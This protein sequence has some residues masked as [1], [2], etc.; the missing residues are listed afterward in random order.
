MQTILEYFE[1][2]CQM[3][4]KSIFIIL[5]YTV[6]KLAR[7][8]ETQCSN[9]SQRNICWTIFVYNMP[10]IFARRKQLYACRINYEKGL[11]SSISLIVC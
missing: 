6:S 5:S 9:R 1:Y 4:S 11:S 8:F 3:S 10:I 2:F 7:F